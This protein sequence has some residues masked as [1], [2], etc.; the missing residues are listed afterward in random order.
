MNPRRYQNELGLEIEPN[1]RIFSDKA[2]E[3]SP[4][5][6]FIMSMSLATDIEDCNSPRL[7][8][9]EKVFVID[10]TGEPKNVLGPNGVKSIP[11]DIFAL[12]ADIP[13][14]FVFIFPEKLDNPPI[15]L[16]NLKTKLEE[17]VPV[18]KNTNLN[19]SILSHQ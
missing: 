10:K 9:N 2:P 12:D 1:N 3:I 15:D 7:P 5:L 13:T 11:W 4:A 16:S 19:F 17:F 8:A 18:S 14:H 6:R